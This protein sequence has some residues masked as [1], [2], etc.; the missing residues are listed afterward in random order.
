MDAYDIVH[1]I[2]RKS[3]VKMKEI[4]G[5][6]GISQQAFYKSLHGSIGFWRMKEIVEIVGY[7]VAIVDEEGKVI[8]EL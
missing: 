3:K 6:L 5:E 1:E 8:K 4:A 7:K 2:S